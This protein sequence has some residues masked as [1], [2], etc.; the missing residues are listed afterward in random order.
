MFSGYMAMLCGKC[1]CNIANVDYYSLNWSIHLTNTKN[2][3]YISVCRIIKPCNVILLI[4]MRKFF[5]VVNFTSLGCD[6][7]LINFFN[8]KWTLSVFKA[9][10]WKNSLWMQRRDEFLENMITE[11]SLKK[12]VVFHSLDWNVTN[13]KFNLNMTG[14]LKHHS[15]QYTDHSNT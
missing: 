11:N 9:N 12:M 14:M 13:Q 5:H 15:H 6:V 7:M 2:I 3:F 8:F 1:Y 4:M 10:I